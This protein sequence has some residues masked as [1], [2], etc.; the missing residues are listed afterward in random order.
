[1]AYEL[2]AEPKP[3]QSNEPESIPAYALRTAG[4]TLARAGE[5]AVGLP[6]DVV[7]GVGTLGLGALNYATQGAT[8]TFSDIAQHAPV[9][10]PTSEYIRENVTKRFTGKALEPK[11]SGEELYDEFIG[12]VASILTPAKGKILRGEIPFKRALFGAAGR[13]AAGNAAK[14]GTEEV[15]GS[16]L[17]G[18]AAKIGVMA[19][20]G[21]VGGRKKIE[22][23]EKKFYKD[24]YANIKP[25]EAFDISKGKKQIDRIEKVVKKGDSPTKKF[26]KDRI[27]AFNE[28]VEQP[29]AAKESETGLLNQ[30]GKPI[31]KTIPGVKGGKAEIEQLIELKKGWNAYLADPK[32]PKAVRGPLKRLIG[33]LKGEIEDYGKTNSEFY[34]NYKIA[35]EL[36]TGLNSSNIVQRIIADSPFLDET[37]K[38]PTLRY[39]LTGK[40]YK[41]IGDF[42]VTQLAGAAAATLAA[43]AG[44]RTF[45]LLL[46]SPYARK[47]YKGFIS[48]TLNNDKKNMIKFGGD[49]NKI[50]NHFFKS[51]SGF[52]L[53]PES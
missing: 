49:L 18:T 46:Q 2:L 10:L 51:K 32:T 12:D 14:W 41:Y 34:K 53:L 52:S 6:A 47:A 27:D 31:T 30:F 21:T 45:Q 11:T 17:A 48:A 24:A 7:K 8:P 23:D 38:N 35:E 1:M 3:Q 40:A 19:L 4:R 29:T 42:P 43:K 16:P 36:H 15:T 20:A 39:L 33:I 50:A 44:A 25:D 13:A 28:I 5:S 22:A 37:I 26:I 9:S